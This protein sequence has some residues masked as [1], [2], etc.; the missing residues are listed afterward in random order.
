LRDYRI[1]VKKSLVRAER[2]IRYLKEDFEG[3]NVTDITTPR[4]QAYIEKRLNEGTEN[5]TINMEL[6]ALKRMLSLGARQRPPKVDRVP[7]VPMLKEL[8][9]RKRFFERNDFLAL[10]NT[11]P[12]YLKALFTFDYTY[13][14]RIN[15]ILGLTWDKVDIK[16]GIV[17][18]STGETKNS[19][20][21]TVYLNDELK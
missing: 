8:N 13:G 11:L 14:W 6:Y 20:G 21:R 1:N 19:E 7:Y 5:A 15:D 10:R 4:I 12:E 2:S 18:L 16:N 17:R 9:T 3:M